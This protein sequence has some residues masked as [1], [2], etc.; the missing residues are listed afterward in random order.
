MK[1]N[2]TF[3][4]IE[5][6]LFDTPGKLTVRGRST[7]AVV[8]ALLRGAAAH[9]PWLRQIARWVEHLA[10]DGWRYRGYDGDVL[11]FRSTRSLDPTEAEAYLQRR[12]GRDALSRVSV[13]ERA[14]Q[15]DGAGRADGEAPVA[16]PRLPKADDELTKE[17]RRLIAP[18]QHQAELYLGHPTE[19][20][21]ELLLDMS[22]LAQESLEDTDVAALTDKLREEHTEDAQYRD[23]HSRYLTLME[24]AGPGDPAAEEAY[25]DL[26]SYTSRKLSRLVPALRGFLERRGFSDLCEHEATAFLT[27]ALSQALSVIEDREE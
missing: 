2:Q 7:K 13:R 17:L 19:E 8:A 22:F 1:R 15:R 20:L 16:P 21:S 4:E 12:F 11:I 23:L 10:E 25:W 26:F 6:R 3:T 14:L 18:E 9:G 27:A 24:R 5:I